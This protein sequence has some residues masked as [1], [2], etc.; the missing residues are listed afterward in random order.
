MR[1]WFANCQSRGA[2]VN[3]GESRANDASL[4]DSLFEETFD[5]SQHFSITD[6]CLYTELFLLPKRPI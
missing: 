6:V 5:K 3:V 4:R 1:H 2:Y